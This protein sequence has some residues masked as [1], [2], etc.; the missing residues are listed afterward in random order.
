M[1][2][3]LVKNLSLSNLT[4]SKSSKKSSKK[5]KSQKPKN[6]IDH[7]KKSKVHSH[8][9][10]YKSRPSPNTSATMYKVGT[11]KKGNDGYNY[12][13]VSIKGKSKIVKRWVKSKSS[14]RLTKRS[15]LS[16]RLKKTKKMKGGSCK[17]SMGQES[18]FNISDT[19]SEGS[20]IIG[21]LRIGSRSFEIG[22]SCN[23]S[24]STHAM[25]V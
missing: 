4:S 9:K 14:K 12:V 13:V 8:L 1:L 6:S 11:V 21:G 23:K 15:T 17:V 19:A 5:T 3:S 10:K 16:K 20:P 25:V 24:G 7:R 18:G 22:R 2:N